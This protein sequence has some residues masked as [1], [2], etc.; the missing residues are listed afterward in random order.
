[1]LQSMHCC[2]HL[3]ATKLPDY[4][5]QAESIIL[6]T[7]RAELQFAWSHITFSNIWLPLLF[8]PKAGGVYRSSYFPMAEK[9]LSHL[10]AHMEPGDEIHTTPK[11][12]FFFKSLYFLMRG[13]LMLI[14][15]WVTLLYIE[16]Q[17]RRSRMDQFPITLPSYVQETQGDK[18]REGS[19]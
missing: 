15:R 2:L 3:S 5:S 18:T 11:L 1:M 7:K 17:G 9:Q 8:A 6:V 4:N 14:Y 12:L 16:G 10:S 13:G 19:K